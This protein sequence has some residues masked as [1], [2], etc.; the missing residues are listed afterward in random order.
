M[1]CTE[2]PKR[3]KVRVK[4]LS[5]GRMKVI[6]FE[7][8]MLLSDIRNTYGLKVLGEFESSG[9]RYM[10]FGSPLIFLY[11]ANKEIRFTTKVYTVKELK[12]LVKLL[13]EAD[14]RLRYLI[15]K[16]KEMDK[17]YVITI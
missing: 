4:K 6:S 2:L 10:Y 13:K 1:A 14:A 7:N 16:K 8:A 5:D 15:K 11:D 9:S 3:I 12:K 17:I